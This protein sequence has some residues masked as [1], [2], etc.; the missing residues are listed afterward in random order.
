M[1]P[2]RYPRANRVGT[3]AGLSSRGVIWVFAVAAAVIPALLWRFGFT[4]ATLA[5]AV[6]VA[7]GV[8]LAIVDLRTNMLPDAV[9]YP[10]LTTGFIVNAHG[11]FAGPLSAIEG[12]LVGFGALWGLN[13]LYRL[14]RDAELMGG[15]DSKLA[16]A[17]GAWLGVA[18]VWQVLALAYAGI[19]LVGAI[20]RRRP[21]L[22]GLIVP[23]GPFL[24]VAGVFTLLVPLSPT[25]QW[26]HAVLS[27]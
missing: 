26:H 11:L 23:F 24:V 2:I 20:V 4:V 25:V 17:L 9:T 1:D 14:T 10:L 18:G 6:L 15:G 19:G 21:G 22:Q 5:A 27:R 13:Q 7:S 12:A 3:S 8:A 16:A